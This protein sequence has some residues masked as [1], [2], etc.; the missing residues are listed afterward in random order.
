LIANEYSGP[1]RDLALGPVYCK[2]VFYETG[3]LGEDDLE[4]AAAFYF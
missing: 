4:K 2:V 1:N 3:E